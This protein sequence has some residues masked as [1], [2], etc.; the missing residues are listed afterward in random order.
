MEAG[1]RGGRP[2]PLLL[3]PLRRTAD[4]GAWL[5]P[6]RQHRLGRRQGGQPERVGVQRRQGRGH[7]ATKS[8]GK[9]L[10]KDG[11]T[12]NALA[13]ASIETPIFAQATPDY[14][15]YARS[16]IPMERLGTVEEAAALISWL[17]SR[18]GSF[19]TGAVFDLSGDRATY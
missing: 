10:V 13:P 15:V 11:V 3:Q 8:L 12:V 2:R 7:R 16:K 1:V 19:S 14:L 17:A 18:E 4:E 5:R 6:R 9:E